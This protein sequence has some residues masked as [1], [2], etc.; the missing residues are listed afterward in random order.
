MS[1]NSSPSNNGS[2]AGRLGGHILVDALVTEGVD[3][4]FGVPGESYLAVIDGLQERNGIRTVMCRQE[5]GAAMMADAYG[6]LTGRPGVCMV[7]RGPGA[8]NASAGVHVAFQDSTPMGL[9]VGQVA[10]WMVEREAFQ[11]IDYRR[12]F[13]QMAKWV[14]EIDDAQRIPEMVSHAFHTATSGRP[15]PVVLALPEDM[16]STPVPAPLLAK[17]Y[18]AS[19]GYPDP[20]LMADFQRRL[21]RAKRPLV[22]VGGGGWS[23][24]AKAE[25]TAALSD[26]PKKEVN[27]Y[28]KRHYPAYWLRVDPAT[29]IEHAQFI[30]AAEK[31]GQT[32]ATTV[33]TNQFQA[34]TEISVL[35]PDHPRLL[36]I[37]AGACSAAGA[38]IVDAQIFT[39]THGRALDTILIGRE[40]DF[41]A[42]ERRRAERV[43][44]LIEDVLSG[45]SYLPEMIEKR[46]KP[47]RGTKAFRVEPR[48]EIGNTLSNRFSV[49]EVK[50]LD[51]AGLL[52]ELTETLSNLSLDIASAHITTFGEKV[53]DTFY[54]TDL[55]GQ[56]IVSPDRLD[57]IRKALLKTLE[58]GSERPARSR[59][60]AAAE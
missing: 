5:G 4:V 37:I 22:I 14:A 49:V 1:M 8:T 20:S 9:L 58:S 25:L 26:W 15:G 19:A 18:H 29:M 36:S 11:E 33:K 51:R 53:I 55:T 60:R 35:A 54:V 32:L 6:K 27:A 50:G 56:K 21:A 34:I 30:R 23:A 48:V 17:P 10:R 40:F 47:R 12:M 59:A 41:D 28:L 3:L 52:S 16:L 44:K 57:A 7:T 38:N 46:A 45:K 39:T 43:R 2:G 13:G 24:E 31:A 42:D